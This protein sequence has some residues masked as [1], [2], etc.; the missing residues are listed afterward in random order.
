MTD[1]M[2]NLPLGDL[3]ALG[4]QLRAD[5]TPE[6]LLQD[7]ADAIRRSLGYR[8]V[9]V[10]LR[11]TD[12]DELEACAFSGLAEEQVARLRT[13]RLAPAEY[14]ALLRP[15][16]RIS[17]S[18]LVPEEDLL[19]A[20]QRLAHQPGGD[21]LLVPLRGRGDRLIGAIYVDPAG[22]PA[23]IELPNI[24]VLEAI[25]RQAGLA[26]ENARLAA[27]TQRLLAKEQLLV[28]LG[29]E[30]SDTLDLGVIL[31]RTVER[32]QMEF[33]GGAIAL[34]NEQN[35]LQIVA[36]VGRIDEDARAVRLKVGEGICGWVVKEGLPFLSNDVWNETRVAP[37][38]C[39]VGTNRLIRSYI[40]VPLRTGGQVIG[41]LTVESDQVNA[42]TYEDV[43]LLEAVAAQVGGP[44]S[45][46]RLYKEAQLLA[47][48]VRRRNKYLEVI[49]TLARMAVSTLDVDRLLATVTAEIQQSFGYGHVELYTVD[50]GARELV[51][52]AQAGPLAPQAVG[53][54]Q[55]VEVGLL[56][57]AF[58]SAATVRVDDV[59]LDPDYIRCQDEHATRSDLCVPVMAGGRV[60][61]LLN[62][63]SPR[64]GAF[65]DDDVAALETAADV[66]AGA[67]EN[68]RLYQR[69]QEAAVLEERSRLARDL[70]DSISQQLFSMTLTAQAARAQLDKNPSRAAA[71]LERLQETASAALAEMR[72]LIFQ[73]RPPGLSEQGLIA[74]LQQHVAMLRRREGLTIDLFVSGEERDAKGIEQAMYRIAQEALN[75]VVKHAGACQVEVML[76]LRP[77]LVMMSISDDGRGFDPAAGNGSGRHLGLVSM[78]ERASELGGRLEI[79]SAPGAGT[80]IQVIGVLTVESDQVNAFTY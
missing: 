20:G 35:E 56:G 73:L 63:Q 8:R 23:A 70:H 40:A 68:A 25:A 1:L 11:N 66:L 32:L 69:A 2:R 44:I 39:D 77:E 29:R 58:R 6:T 5:I 51:L 42:F 37:A 28:E 4:T 46:A 75:N 59:L 34:L 15:Q 78:H 76:D 74:T 71:Q 80:R 43:D 57:R 18:Y 7:V 60:M 33:Q 14:Q 65:T 12:T 22:D 53:Y 13:R 30:V 45:S 47:E 16:Y 49:N 72:A 64:V 26:L 48:Q 19:R 61:A 62:L 31:A 67:I 17:E 54:R 52:V 50:E 55:P 38:A 79:Q 41:V 21:T 9:Y 10:R 24:K 27:R 3:L 36:S